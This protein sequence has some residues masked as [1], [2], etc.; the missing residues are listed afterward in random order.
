MDAETLDLAR[1]FA[2]CPKWVWLPGMIACDVSR[3]TTWR[4]R[5]LSQGEVFGWKFDAVD[6]PVPRGPW[7]NLDG[8]VPDL[9]DDLTRIG[10]L[11]V[12]RR[13]WRDDSI[14]ITKAGDEWAV[15]MAYTKIASGDARMAILRS[16]PTE[17]GAL[18]AASRRPA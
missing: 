13:A 8:W 4:R 11:A 15:T 5:L 9:S 17:L 14:G 16:G 7:R 2:A 18:L 10:V 1:R 12:V 6:G 3:P